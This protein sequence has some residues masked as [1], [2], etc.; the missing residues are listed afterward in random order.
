[1]SL[2]ELVARARRLVNP[3][4]RAL[5]GIAGA[6]GAGKTTLALALV[7][8][9]GS[10]AVHV[11]MDGFHLADVELDRLGRRARKGAPDTFDADGY[12]TLLGQLREPSSG[13]VYAPAFDREI[14]QPI[15]GSIPVTS[16]CRLVVSEG[17]YL[18][19]DDPA[20]RAVRARFDEVWFHETDE[21]ARRER[22]VGRH[23]RFG[24]TRDEA[25]AW[26]EA[27]DEPNARL[28]EAT[29]SRADL[30]TAWEGPTRRED[31]VG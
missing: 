14:E 24:K 22:L 26:V 9:L 15:A 10:E 23:V 12:A 31:Q 29:R 17:N 21:V 20:W 19:V 18:L 5:L 13:T 8:A 3:D 30:T 11:P 28:I 4:R 7:E 2:E 27:I 1:M 6:P 16:S 25:V